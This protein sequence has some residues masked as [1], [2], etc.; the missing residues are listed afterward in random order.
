MKKTRGDQEVEARRDKE[1]TITIK[2][3]L[4]IVKATLV[5]VVSQ[6]AAVAQ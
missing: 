4:V 5:G 3:V 2:K 1:D 6:L